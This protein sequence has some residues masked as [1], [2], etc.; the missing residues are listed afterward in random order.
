MVHIS[1]FVH[2]IIV[3]SAVGDQLLEMFHLFGCFQQFPL[4]QDSLL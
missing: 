1:I 4:V 3:V 2:V